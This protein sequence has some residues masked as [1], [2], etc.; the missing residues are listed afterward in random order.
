MLKQILTNPQMQEVFVEIVST[1]LAIALG[2]TPLLLRWFRAHGVNISA[3]QE[4]RI[5]AIAHIAAQGVEEYTKQAAK[6]GLE[7]KSNEKL[8]LAVKMA[9]DLAVDGLKAYADDKIKTAI[10][11]HLP[12][13][14][15]RLTVP[16]PPPPA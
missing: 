2:A 13:M 15:A 7:L 4:Q 16:P 8:D 5:L 12:A 6:N 10:E 1:L 9:R 3:A 11:A 14:R